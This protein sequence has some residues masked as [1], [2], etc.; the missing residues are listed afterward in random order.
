MTTKFLVLFQNQVDQTTQAEWSLSFSLGD[1]FE[2]QIDP[3]EPL[4]SHY[5]L[6][7]DQYNKV[8]TVT[9]IMSYNTTPS[10]RF[11]KV[12]VLNLKPVH[13]DSILDMIVEFRKAAL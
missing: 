8:L 12:P 4:H 5:V 10:N 3:D 13:L 1:K 2:T 6:P 11:F 7:I 9:N